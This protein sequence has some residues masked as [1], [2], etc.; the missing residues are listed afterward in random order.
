ML[1]TL[2]ETARAAG[3]AILTHYGKEIPVDH[4]ADDSPL[5]QADLAAHHCILERLNLHF[6]DIPVVSEEGELPDPSTIGNR[7][8][9]V[10]PLDGTKEFIG[11]RGSFTVNI[12]LIEN[13]I[14]ILGIVHAPALGETYWAAQ[15]EGAWHSKGDTA[16]TAI[17]ASEPASPLRIVASR[18]HAGPEVQSLLTRFPDASCL[19]I[20]SS[21]KFCLVAAGK[22]DA[23]LRDVPTMEWDTAAAHAIIRE[24]GAT[25]VNW[26]SLTPLRYGKSGWR[27]AS[28]LTAASTTLAHSLLP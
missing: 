23:Y 5:T 27:N 24:A 17:R 2:L 6:P 4:K 18:D 12:A 3:E 20:G 13:G 14:P 25:L 19:S 8:W 28:I 26:P 10:D 11:K 1:N 22:A 15:G 7:F 9:L 21:L 16:P